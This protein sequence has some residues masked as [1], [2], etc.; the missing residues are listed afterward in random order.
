MRLTGMHFILDLGDA[1]KTGKIIGEVSGTNFFV[2]V[3]EA[4]SPDRQAVM[5]MELISHSKLEDFHPDGRRHWLMFRS[6]RHLESFFRKFLGREEEAAPAEV[7]QFTKE[8][9]P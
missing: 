3:F 2:A 9:K 1:Y 8:K 7:L 5:P 6:R 4:D